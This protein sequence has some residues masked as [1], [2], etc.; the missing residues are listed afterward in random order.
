MADAGVGHARRE[1]LP[2]LLGVI[3]IISGVATGLFSDLPTY[4]KYFGAFV[5]L[6]WAAIIARVLWNPELTDRVRRLTI[7]TLVLTA[8]LVLVAAW[9]GP[10]MS[11]RTLLLSAEGA[12]NLN[13]A[14]MGA[15]DGR[16]TL[17][18]E[19]ALN[20][21]QGQ[22]VHITPKKGACAGDDVRLRASDLLAVAP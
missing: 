7:L 22:L 20:Q 3:T 1:N 6:L 14:C 21:L 16:G 15:A 10:R 2:L 9:S 4:G 11:G 17:A 12:R 8:V 19:V 18:A 5:F 13:T